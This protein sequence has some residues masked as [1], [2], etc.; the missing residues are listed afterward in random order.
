MLRRAKVAREVKK[1]MKIEVSNA[2][3]RTQYCENFDKVKQLYYIDGMPTLVR[4][5]WSQLSQWTVSVVDD[6]YLP[7][8]DWF[9]VD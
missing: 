4:W 8:F 9:G 1:K 7:E 5:L 3:I 2:V 6:L